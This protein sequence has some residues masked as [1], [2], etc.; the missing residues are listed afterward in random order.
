[1]ISRFFIHH[2]IFAS[3]L[4]LLIVFAGLVAMKNLP[5]E[6]FPNITPPLI[7]VT[8]TY[9]GANADTMAGD[10]AS[11]LEQ[12]ILGVENMIYMYSQN[13][14]SGTMTLDVYFAI[15]S[16]ADMAQVNVQNQVNQALSQLPSPVQKEGVSILKQTPNILLIV[17]MQSTDPRYDQ[18]FVSNYA[19][20]NVVTDLQLLPGISTISVIGQRNYAIRIWLK[21]DRMAQMGISPK[22]VIDSVRGCC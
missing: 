17:A 16:S 6:Q 11:P 14:S 18:T 2:P 13:S 15:G 7:Q 3:A 22:D 9:N 10:V 19:N 20:I 4:S 21:P 1:M 12:Q 8:T 5:V